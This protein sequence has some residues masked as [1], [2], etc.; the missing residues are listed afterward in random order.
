M[1]IKNPQYRQLIE[2][3]FKSAAFVN[4]IGISLLGCGPG[5]CESGMTILPRHLQQGGVVHAG[6]Q[7]TIADHTAGAA[8]T[9]MLAQGQY[10]LTAE[11]KINLLRSAVG[12]TL[13]CRAQVLKPGK[14]LIIVE[15]EVFAVSGTTMTLVSKMTATMSVA[16]AGNA[17]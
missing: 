1:E 2:S 12:E 4:D 10:V 13:F 14:A 9:T 6:V 7:A 8:A 5:W 17:L 16:V 3:V 11:F 15:A